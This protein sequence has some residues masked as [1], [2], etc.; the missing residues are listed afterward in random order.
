VTQLYEGIS[1]KKAPFQR[2]PL[3]LS[4]PELFES[5]SAGE[6]A[7][8]RAFFD[9]H[10]AGL[11]ARTTASRS[12]HAPRAPSGVLLRHAVLM[13]SCD[14]AEQIYRVCS[15]RL[16]RVRQLADG[17]RQIFCVYLPG[18]IIGAGGLFW[19]SRRDTI[20]ALSGA[21]VQTLDAS[22]AREIMIE[23]PEAALWLLR[24]ILAEERRLRALI[25]G[26]GR[27]DALTRV[28]WFLCDLSD[29]LRRRGLAAGESFILAMTQQDIGDHLGLTPVSVNRMLK[30]LRESGVLIVHRQIAVITN[31][32]RL[33]ELA[34]PL[35]PEGEALGVSS[36]EPAPPDQSPRR[37][38]NPAA[39]A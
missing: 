5:L 27:A 34:M 18:D 24:R 25:T 21:V 2:R 19:P 30:E 3:S 16:C 14:P 1:Q 10:P 39:V 4:R 6:D 32:A 37:V 9:G 31:R 35:L 17:R 29:R 13:R 28:A 20:E 26:L 38:S 33:R 8:A 36:T 11:V 23:Q 15:G 22:L 7:F 12:P